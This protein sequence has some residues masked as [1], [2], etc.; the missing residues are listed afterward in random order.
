MSLSLESLGLDKER[1][2]K[3]VV[4]QICDQILAEQC[5]DIGDDEFA[6]HSKLYAELNEMAKKRIDEHVKDMADKYVMPKIDEIVNTIVIKK[7]NTYGEPKGES[8]TLVEYIT[9]RADEYLREDVDYQG[10]TRGESSYN[11]SKSQ[12]RIVHMID[13][14]LHYSIDQAMKESVKTINTAV[15]DGLANTAKLKL[16]DINEKIHKALSS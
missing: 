16:Q 9:K 15:V 3:M 6:C 4:D 10:K 11:W 12:S 14:H 7:T 5:L 2:E 13:K 1:I 8:M